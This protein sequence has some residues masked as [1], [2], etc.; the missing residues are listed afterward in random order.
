MD[1]E[2]RRDGLEPRTPRTLY[3]R[4]DWD[5][6]VADGTLTPQDVLDRLTR[7][8]VSAFGVGGPAAY[9]EDGFFLS[10]TAEGVRPE[11]SIT[12][13]VNTNDHPPPHVH[14]LKPG[15]KGKLKIDLETGE[16][17][18]DVP[19][20]LVGK[21]RGIRR[22][23]EENRTRLMSLWEKGPGRAVR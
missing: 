19:R 13:H 7:I 10:L 8:L 2:D 22:A 9:D 11:G 18:G 17:I 20:G 6:A 1:D 4:E 5:D 23:V 15:M 21:T 16:F 14:V 12:L 3:T